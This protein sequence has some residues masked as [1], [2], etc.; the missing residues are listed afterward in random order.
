VPGSAPFYSFIET[1]Y[2]HNLISGYTCSP[3]CLEFR[4]G[5]SA[6]RGQI[7]KIVYQAAG[8]F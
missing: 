6:T 4:P 1:A 2:S 7:S 8:P 3:G 5:S